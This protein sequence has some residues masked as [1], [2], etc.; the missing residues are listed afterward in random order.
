MILIKRV[1]YEYQK[2][3]KISDCIIKS[4]WVNSYIIA[5]FY[6]KDFCHHFLGW[7]QPGLYH[8][9]ACNFRKE[10]TLLND[11]LDYLRLMAVIILSKTWIGRETFRCLK[12][13]CRHFY[14]KQYVLS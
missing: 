13:A 10:L 8:L 9:T 14:R 4:I 2:T 11:T 7:P 5:K 12:R 3:H 6:V 1:D